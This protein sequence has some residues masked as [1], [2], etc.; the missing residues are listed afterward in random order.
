M[1]AWIL[2]ILSLLQRKRIP[3]AGH[4]GFARNPRQRSDDYDAI[5]PRTLPSQFAHQRSDLLLML[6]VQPHRCPTD[7]Q[8]S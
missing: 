7:N 1:Y 6:P 4:Q 3:P 2:S 8:A 5:P